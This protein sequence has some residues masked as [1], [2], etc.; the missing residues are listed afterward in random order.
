[1]LVIKINNLE[2]L[3]RMGDE[4][5]AF[6]IDSAEDVLDP[7]LLEDDD[8]ATVPPVDEDEDKDED[9]EAA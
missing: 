5:A 6:G 8:D 4:A 2:I 7:A 1:V 3:K 9:E